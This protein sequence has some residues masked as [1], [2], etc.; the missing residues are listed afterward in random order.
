M[1]RSGLILM[2]VVLLLA[3]VAG[4]ALTHDSP[5]NVPRCDVCA[6]GKAG[7]TL[8]CDG[9]SKGFVMGSPVN[10]K[11]QG[12]FTQMTGGP[13]CAACAARNR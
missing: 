2:A 6:Q 5:V 13:E 4:C 9:C 7:E 10:T 11:C 12:C 1:Q 3:G 8:W